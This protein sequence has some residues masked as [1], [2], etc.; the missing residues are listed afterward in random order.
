MSMTDYFPKF[1]HLW[2]QLLNFEPFLEF[3][4][5]A[6][7][8][9]S[10]SHD[11]A[12]AMRF[13]MGLNENFETLRSQILMFDPFPSMS[14]VYTLVLQEESHKNIGQ[15]GSCSSQP[16]AVAMYAN[17]KGNSNWNKGSGKKERPFCT[18]CN[19]PEHT[20]EN[21]T[22]FMVIHMDISLRG[23]PL[24]MQIRFPLIQAM[25]LLLRMP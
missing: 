21:T 23:S 5:G 14:K 7:K 20:I 16:N 8:V 4:C 19:M 1:K 9:L 12:Y 2:D 22:N 11:K 3:S 25:L 15:G 13:L 18:Y 10:A 17:L 24:P 6:M